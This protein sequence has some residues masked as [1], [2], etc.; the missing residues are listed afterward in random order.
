MELFWNEIDKATL[1]IEGL[2]E[3]FN[4][5]DMKFLS[6]GKSAISSVCENLWGNSRFSSKL[7]PSRN[8]FIYH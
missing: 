1:F 6:W 5:H 8:N 4:N 3:A 2:W 7:K